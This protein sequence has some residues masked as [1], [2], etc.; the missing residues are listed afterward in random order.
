MPINNISLTIAHPR[1]I[2]PLMT[3][4]LVDL[5]SIVI[6]NMQGEAIGWTHEHKHHI[7]FAKGWDTHLAE[8][9]YNSDLSSKVSGYTI[10]FFEINGNVSDREWNVESKFIYPPLPPKPY[11]D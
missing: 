3:A 7:N 5:Q 10:S 2:H 8:L 4:M 1:V 9:K 11:H 6:Y